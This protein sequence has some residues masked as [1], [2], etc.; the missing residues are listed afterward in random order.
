VPEPAPVVVPHMPEPAGLKPVE[1]E[2]EESEPDD[3]LGVGI[4]VAER[5]LCGAARA[6]VRA[7]P[8]A[9]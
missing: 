8:R 7:W 1:C 5:A 2:I 3:C 6:C 4:V 9:A